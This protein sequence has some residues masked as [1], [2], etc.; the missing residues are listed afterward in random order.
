MKTIK[1]MLIIVALATIG[2]TSC[3]KGG[4]SYDYLECVTSKQNRLEILQEQYEEDID[5]ASS[6][7]DKVN[8]TRRY[9]VKIEEINNIKCELE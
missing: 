2:L 9:E 5:R 4:K 7:S 6:N 8:I 3:T 1:I